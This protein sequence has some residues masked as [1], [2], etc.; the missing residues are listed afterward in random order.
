VTITLADVGQAGLIAGDE[1][2]SEVQEPV[3]AIAERRTVFHRWLVVA[4]HTR[5]KSRV[6]SGD[7]SGFSKRVVFVNPRNNVDNRKR[8]GR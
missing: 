4:E 1:S 8:Y 3:T 5:D 2:D 7:D 6:S